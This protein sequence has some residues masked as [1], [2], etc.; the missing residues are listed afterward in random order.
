MNKSNSNEQFAKFDLQRSRLNSL[1]QEGR[2]CFSE[3]DMTAWATTCDDLSEKLASARFKVIVLGEFKRGKSTFINSLLGKEVLPA[4][5]TPC[6]A[7]INELKWNDEP[8]AVLHFKNPLPV[9]LPTGLPQEAIRHLEKYRGKTVDPLPI[10]VEEL[11]KYVV[12]QDP[13]KDQSASIAETPYERV[14]LGWPLELLQNG[15]EIIDSP[16]LNEHGSRTKVTMDY[17]GKIDAVI[18]VLSVHALASQTEISVIDRELRSSGHEYLFFVCNRFDELKRT[19]ERDRIM[20]YAYDHL[21]PRTALGKEGVYFVSALDAVIGR[22]EKDAGMIER[23]KIPLVERALADFLVEHRGRVKL[24]QPAYQLAQG[25]KSAL[26][27]TIPQRRKMLDSNMEELEVR[28]REA[29]PQ[30]EDAE[31]RKRKKLESLERSRSR[32]RD[33]V[34]DAAANHLRAVADSVPEW[35]SSLDLESKI[36]V[37]Q[38]WRIE[39]QVTTLADEVVTRV[40][41]MIE[42]ATRVWQEE[43]LAPLV[44]DHLTDFQADAKEAL[45]DFLLDME[46]IRSKLTG[47]S[48][49]E[50]LPEARVG[51]VERLLAGVGG[52]FL[53]GAGSAIEGATMGYQ[54]MLRS[55]VP[56]ILVVVGAVM[57]LHL[58]PITIIPALIATGIYR[59]LR[60]GSALTSRAKS[61]IGKGLREAIIAAIPDQSREIADKVHERTEGVL[62]AIASSMDRELDTVRQQVN[63]ILEVKRAGAEKIAFEKNHASQVET[64]LK[65]VENAVSDFIKELT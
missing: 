50:I 10:P 25:L 38:F 14:E 8:K 49:D 7:I 39:D 28:V 27:E 41:P 56:S 60:K 15:V 36:S 21:A 9:K 32:L 40:Q 2:S 19:V 54:G 48:T 43:R 1:F 20:Q 55:L 61:E 11:E 51:A 52:F 5:A 47:D 34:R 46:S 6:T 33:A 3:I 45:Q 23:S 62:A 31:Q 30:L 44:S 18:F 12:I 64:K 24:L 53:G 4:F 16:G 17:L 26:F 22:E 59:S 58:N 35:A 13:T 42:A 65:Q 57:I 29:V 37:M 63:S